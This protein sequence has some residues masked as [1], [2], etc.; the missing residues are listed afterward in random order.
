[1][2]KDLFLQAAP[3]LQE[4]QDNGYEAYYVGGLSVTI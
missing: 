3:I 4:I 2:N 1:M